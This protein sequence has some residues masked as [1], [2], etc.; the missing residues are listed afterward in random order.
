MGHSSKNIPLVP[1]LPLSVWTGV[2]AVGVNVSW[3]WSGLRPTGVSKTTGQISRH[4]ISQ[5]LWGGAAT[6]YELIINLARMVLNR[7]IHSIKTGSFLL[8]FFTFMSTN[9][10]PRFITRGS[11]LDSLKMHFSLWPSC[12]GGAG[13]AHR[14][15]ET[16]LWHI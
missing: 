6:G 10:P 5:V 16:Q 12:Q 13:G 4:S 7:K 8:G 14:V 3:R 1:L 11:R 2:K 9:S 15:L